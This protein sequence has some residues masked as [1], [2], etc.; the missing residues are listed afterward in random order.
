MDGG[1][2][3]DRKCRKRSGREDYCNLVGLW[4]LGQS[5]AGEGGSDRGEGKEEGGVRGR[6]REEGEEEGGG[7][8][9]RDKG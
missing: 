8:G 7:G 3:L 5:H 9:K 1:R 2:G 4:W 6:D